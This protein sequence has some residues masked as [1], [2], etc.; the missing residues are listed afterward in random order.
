MS[1]SWMQSPI[2]NNV[3]TSNNLEMKSNHEANPAQ[4]NNNNIESIEDS[5]NYSLNN[6]TGDSYISPD[7]YQ[8]SSESI[9]DDEVGNC[10]EYAN[11]TS[12]RIG[13]ILT[14]LM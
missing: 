1:V 13:I 14:E 7:Y 11:N 3:A 10:Q 2:I 9:N 6:N 12:F 4:I 5:P 8:A